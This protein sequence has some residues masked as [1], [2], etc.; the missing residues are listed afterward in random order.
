MKETCAMAPGMLIV[1]T[2]YSIKDNNKRTIKVVQKDRPS[3]V[4]LRF[5]KERT[6]KSIQDI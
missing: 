1:S 4:Q 3:Q 2:D 6:I 5:L